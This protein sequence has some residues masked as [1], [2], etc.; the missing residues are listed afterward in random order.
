MLITH[1]LDDARVFGEHVLQLRDGAI[2][3]SDSGLET[4][5]GAVA[6]KY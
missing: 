5:H 4:R 1:D 2:E 3:T 6:A